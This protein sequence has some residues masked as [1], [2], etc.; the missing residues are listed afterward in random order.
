[1]ANV[2]SS[3]RQ[4]RHI[5]RAR[6]VP[7]CIVLLFVFRMALANAI[8]PPW[9]NPDE[10]THFAFTRMLVLDAG[11]MEQGV[12]RAVVQSEI[13]E[14][15]A[16]HGWWDAYNKQVPSPFPTSFDEVPEHLNLGSSPEFDFY[17]RMASAFLLAT[18]TSSL[19]S[20]YTVL[21][22]LSSVLAVA[23]L[24]CV[25]AGT[26]RLMGDEVGIGAAALLALHPQ[27]ALIGLGVAPDVLVNLCG[28]VVWWQAARLITDGT[29]TLSLACMFVATS[30]GVLSKRAFVPWFLV[31]PL[32]GSVGVAM[33][34]EWDTIWRRPS[35]QQF[36]SAS[37]IVAILVGVAL[38][39]QER[40]LQTISAVWSSR[41]PVV[42]DFGCGSDWGELPW[43]WYGFDQLE[44][45]VDLASTTEPGSFVP[46]TLGLLDT[47]WLAGG[48]LRF[49]GPSAWYM[50]VR[51]LV[52]LA[53][54]GLL[55]ACGA[56]AGHRRREIW[57][58]AVVVGVQVGAVYFDVYDRGVGPQGRYLFPAIGPAV[59][60][61]WVGLLSPWPP[62][63]KPSVGATV[64][65]LMATLDIAAWNW[66]IL[67]AYVH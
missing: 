63:M 48:W 1:M 39:S 61:M 28:A 15:M 58:A 66:V 67:P 47:A 31:T 35:R 12:A 4:V 32:L 26:T 46:F 25:W 29:I 41:T 64:I 43:F 14:S 60:L 11:G 34:T 45:G 44:T 27:F 40:L 19:M 6:S 59:A 20:Q 5:W 36:W 9:Q 49:M 10:T 38:V 24:W 54:L 62:R 42:C 22:L 18:G 30:V 8:V 65:A 52:L 33:R 57:L 56:Y 16:E 7:Y 50:V 55:I 3:E 53:A 23:T 21:R 17:Y 2:D 51:G 13:L 37:V